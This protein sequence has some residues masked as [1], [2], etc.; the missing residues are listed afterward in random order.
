PEAIF[1]LR[2]YRT[3]LERFAATVPL[4]TTRMLRDRRISAAFKDL[5]GGQLLGPTF[6]YTHRLLDFSLLDEATPAHGVQRATAAVSVGAQV[7][8]EQAG[9]GDAA[10][11]AACPRVVDML[12]QEGLLGL[13][14]VHDEDVPDITR[15]PLDFPTRREQRLQALA[16]GDEGFLLALG[17]STQRGYGRNHPFAGEIR[18]G[19]VEV[20]IEPE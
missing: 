20:W 15:E 11:A 10:D 18:I 14:D 8:V 12:A 4:E 9:E 17:Y 13:D 2:A 16:R 5:P 3:T 7:A 6:D 1:L 19:S